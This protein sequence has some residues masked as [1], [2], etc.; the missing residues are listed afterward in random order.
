MKILFRMFLVTSVLVLGITFG[1]NAQSNCY[2]DYLN[3]FTS[4]GAAAIPD[5]TQEVVATI[6]DGSKSDCYLAKVQVKNNQIVSV[7]GV[8][9]EDGTVKKMG[10]K[11]SPKYKDPNNPAILF[12]EITDGMSTTLLSDD[13]KLVNFF[14]IKQL[15]AK[16]KAYKL[17]PPA[18]SF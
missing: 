6:R 11:L 18:S 16:T 13:N 17:A 2:E 14:F 1:A 15:N 5:G 9:L 10:M 12:M 8:I 4:R 3:L 7:D